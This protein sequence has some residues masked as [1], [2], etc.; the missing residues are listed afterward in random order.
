MLWIP[1]VLLVGDHW[2]S[3]LIANE[4]KRLQDLLNDKT[5]EHLTLADARLY[6]TAEMT[7]AAAVLPKAVVPKDNIVFAMITDDHHEAPRKRAN[8]FIRKELFEVYL[9]IPSMEVKGFVHLH[10]R[11]DPSGFL[12]RLAKDNITF[13]PVTQSAVSAVGPLAEASHAPVTLVNRLH[14]DIF[15]LAENPTMF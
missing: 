6:L 9:T 2:I 7:E 14:V 3:A 15:Y 8:S 12:T 11:S 1:V 13:F 10:Q 5:S 4:G